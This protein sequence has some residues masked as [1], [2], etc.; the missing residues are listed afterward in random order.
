MGATRPGDLLAAVAA[1]ETGL[2]GC[3]YKFELG[4][5]VG[6]AQRLLGEP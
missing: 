2:R 6:A 3:G 5:G 4:A 1:V